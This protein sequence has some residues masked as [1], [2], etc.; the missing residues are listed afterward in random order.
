[1]NSE[2]CM[3]LFVSYKIYKKKKVSRFIQVYSEQKRYFTE[4]QKRFQSFLKESK[5]VQSLKKRIKKSTKPS[6]VLPVCPR[7]GPS[8]AKPFLSSAQQKKVYTNPLEFRIK[9]FFGGSVKYL[10]CLECKT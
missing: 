7:E 9:P 6:K 4:P 2:T 1:M 5:W 10:F 8:P 3:I